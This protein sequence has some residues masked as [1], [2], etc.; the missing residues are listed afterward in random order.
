MIALS[1]G[2]FCFAVWLLLSGLFKPL[3]LALGLLSCVLAV[4]VA[5]RMG[6]LQD[7]TIAPPQALRFLLYL[8]WL[9]VEIAKS[10]V[11]VIRRILSPDLPISPELFRL[12]ISQQSDLGR[13]LFANSIT[14]T[15]GTVAIQ[16]EDHH[17]EVHALTTATADALRQGEMDRR[18]KRVE[19]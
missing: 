11:D 1:L 7:D 13:V 17:I 9:L 19:G 16:V 5:R 10:N 6:L 12:Q 3:L 15:P 8:P 4:W 18:V 2:L 14:L